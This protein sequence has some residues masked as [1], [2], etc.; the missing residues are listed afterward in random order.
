MIR[1]D[2]TVETCDWSGERDRAALIAVREEVFVREQNVPLEMEL[3]ED[4]PR[5]VHVLA[6]TDEGTP[7]G[8]GRLTPDGKIGRMAVMKNRRATGI[9]TAILRVLLEQARARGREQV[10]LHAQADAVAFYTKHGFAISGDDFMEAGILHRPMRL[11]LQSPETPP[12]APPRER[13]VARALNANSREQL[14]KATFTLLGNTRQVLRILVRELNPLLLDDSACLVE[15][16]RIAISSRAASIRI[17]AQ[18]I[19][20]AQRGGNRVLELAQRL[21][22]VV[23]LRQPVEDVDRGYSSAFMSSDS[24]G[25]LFRPIAERMDCAGSTCA[26]GRAAQLDALFDAVWERSKPMSELRALKI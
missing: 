16:R 25:F 18:D 12:R 8:A 1:D 3:D 21:P 17:L 26:P 20:R 7:V 2:F 6:R 4:D 19:S 11:T 14:I 9:G 15:L 23:Q 22:S 24:G 13:P 10:I 5:S